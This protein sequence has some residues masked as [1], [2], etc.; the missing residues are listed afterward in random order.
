MS[1]VEIPNAAWK[2]RYSDLVEEPG[3]R[4]RPSFGTILGMLPEIL[5]MRGAQ[6]R[7]IKMGHEPL[8]WLDGPRPGPVMGVPLGGIGGGTVTRGWLGDFPRFQMHPG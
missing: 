7:A 8:D 4:G 1:P 2:R 5:R 6:S 3:E